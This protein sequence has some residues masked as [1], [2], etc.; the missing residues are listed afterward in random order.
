[1]RS[2]DATGDG[3]GPRG[4]PASEPSAPEGQPG[5]E[6]R[7]DLGL[8][9]TEQDLRISA[10]IVLHL[11]RQP[12]IGPNDPA[13]ESM[14]QAGMAAALGTTQAAVSHALARLVY[15]G[16]LQVQK[17]HVQGRGQRV[18]VYQLTPNGEALAR[19]I[20]ESMLS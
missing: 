11:S 2:P 8:E 14:T 3:R 12:R 7:K 16:L 17:A 13:P 10:K 20:R 1:M 4:A 9:P 19:Y 18:K 15:G 6:R 5:N